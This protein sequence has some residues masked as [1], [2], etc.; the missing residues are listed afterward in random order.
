MIRHIIFRIWTKKVQKLPYLDLQ[1]VSLY[2]TVS[3]DQ[4]Q[5]CGGNFPLTIEI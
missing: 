5:L 2:R 3:E 1:I 4:F